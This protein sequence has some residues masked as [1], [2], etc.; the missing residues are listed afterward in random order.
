MGASGESLLIAFFIEGT[1]AWAV[2]MRE[3]LLLDVSGER[4]RY[5]IVL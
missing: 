1:E 3:K 2:A 5:E 4:R